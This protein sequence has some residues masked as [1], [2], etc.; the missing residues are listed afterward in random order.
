MTLQYTWSSNSFPSASG[1]NK[2]ITRYKCRSVS[3]CSTDITTRAIYLWSHSPPPPPTHPTHRD[4]VL[5]CQHPNTEGKEKHIPTHIT[6]PYRDNPMHSQFRLLIKQL[7]AP[8]TLTSGKKRRYAL[9]STLGGLRTFEKRKFPCSYLES[10]PGWS[11]PLLGSGTTGALA[12]WLSF[13]GRVTVQSHQ[14]HYR[15]PCTSL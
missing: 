13:G 10:S 11:S 8:A 4:E 15:H 3:P 6:Q 5:A 14:N 9:N 2:V 12:Q 7:Q 1:D